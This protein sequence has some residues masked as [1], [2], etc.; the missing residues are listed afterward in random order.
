MVR[1]RPGID[2]Q[3]HKLR[4]QSV[5]DVL[6]WLAILAIGWLIASIVVSLA[7]GRWFRW[8]RGDFD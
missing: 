3:T 6:L 5:T 2:P 1:R 8:V 4:L 7:A